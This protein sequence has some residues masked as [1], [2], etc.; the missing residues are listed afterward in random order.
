MQIVITMSI[1]KGQPQQV[2][3]DAPEGP[4]RNTFAIHH[5]H[6]VKETEPPGGKW[7]GQ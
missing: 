7:T 5:V 2:V 1:S 3:Q 4:T 6:E